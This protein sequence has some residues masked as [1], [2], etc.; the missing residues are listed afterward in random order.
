MMGMLRHGLRSRSCII[1]SEAV[2]CAAVVVPLIDLR[3]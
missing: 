1:D 2:A 3:W